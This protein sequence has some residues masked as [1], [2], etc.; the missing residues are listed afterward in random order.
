MLC[1]LIILILL[2]KCV[3]G[4]TWL[5]L[6]PVV[7][8]LRV[9][10]LV[11]HL[12]ARYAVNGS[13]WLPIFPR[14]NLLL[15]FRVVLCRA[16]KGEVCVCL[17]LCRLPGL[18]R[19]G[20]CRLFGLCLLLV[21]RCLCFR[22]LLVEAGFRR[23]LLRSGTCCRS[24]LVQLACLERLRHLPVH[25]LVGPYHI[26]PR[27]RVHLRH[28]AVHRLIVLV[29]HPH[30]VIHLRV[31]LGSKP[32]DLVGTLSGKLL[33]GGFYGRLL[34]LLGVNRLVHAEDVVRAH[35]LRLTRLRITDDNRR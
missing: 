28:H 23:A 22:L 29:L 11:R 25:G 6:F 20:L 3:P 32:V 15:A 31:L 13:L 19:L 8:R 17:R 18:R 5:R 9:P 24:H 1:P 30:L 35:H 2:V 21:I 16:L 7:H 4:I 14:L 26:F 34:L 33:P 27:H 10:L 12:L